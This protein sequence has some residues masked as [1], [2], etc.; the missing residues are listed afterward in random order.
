MS[1]ASLSN[2]YNVTLEKKGDLS[3]AESFSRRSLEGYTSRNVR[4][5]VEDGVEL[6]TDILQAQNKMEEASAIEE[7]YN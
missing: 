5:D 2:S 4:S 3:S 6:L 1:P 7:Q